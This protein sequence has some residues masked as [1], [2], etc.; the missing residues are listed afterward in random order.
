MDRDFASFFFGKPKH[1]TWF[2]RVLQRLIKR[3]L[4]MLSHCYFAD[5]PSTLKKL[6][7]DIGIHFN[8]MNIASKGTSWV[9]HV[10]T[11]DG[12]ILLFW[13][14]DQS[15]FVGTSEFYLWFI[16]MDVDWN[17]DEKCCLF[18]KLKRRNNIYLLNDHERWLN[19]FVFFVQIIS[20]DLSVQTLPFLHC[21]VHQVLFIR[22]SLSTVSNKYLVNDLTNI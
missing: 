3:A 7:P 11:S 22:F 4:L 1:T 12:T 16:R 5:M 2:M 13:H 20:D 10:S 6:D 19:Q 9:C 21:F 14:K 8:R 17:I 15:K 18:V